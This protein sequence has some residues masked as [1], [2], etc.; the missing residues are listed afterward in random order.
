VDNGTGYLGRGFTYDEMMETITKRIVDIV[1]EVLEVDRLEK[2][3]M[4]EVT[5]LS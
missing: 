2:S 5:D 1:K 4:L 3:L